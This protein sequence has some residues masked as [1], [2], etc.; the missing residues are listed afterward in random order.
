MPDNP[1]TVP[2]SEHDFI[3]VQ[4]VCCGHTAR[5]P[6]YCGNRFCNI[7]HSQRQKRVKNRINWLVRNRPKVKGTMLKHLT[8]TVRNRKDLDGMVRH[9]VKSFRK[10]RQRKYF[11]KHVI[12]GAFVVE[13][14]EKGNGWHAH[15]HCIIQAYL[16]EWEIFRDMWKQCT[17]GDTGIDI[18]NRSAVSCVQYLTKYI[19]KSELPDDLQQI[20]SDAL[21]NYRLFNP[22][23]DWYAINKKYVPPTCTCPACNAVNS[24]LPWDIIFGDWKG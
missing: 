7:C 11:K 19:S 3:T 10:F 17:G 14:T 24:Y 15:I 21:K 20:A 12:G 2:G 6:V 13:I 4:C 23:G 16:V 18:R 9:L 1:E 5:V 8:L 22:F